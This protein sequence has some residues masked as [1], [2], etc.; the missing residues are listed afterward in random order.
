VLRDKKVVS[1]FVVFIAPLLT[2]AK[3]DGDVHEKTKY[4][5]KI[6]NTVYKNKKI[7]WVSKYN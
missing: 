1:V 7:H 3:E 4:C 2:L 5:K 6:K